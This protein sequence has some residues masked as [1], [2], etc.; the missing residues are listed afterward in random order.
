MLG[1]LIA[2]QYEVLRAIVSGYSP[3]CGT[4]HLGPAE[5]GPPLLA[6]DPQP[7]HHKYR[8]VPAGRIQYR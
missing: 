6:L 4:P 7:E 2:S 3:C 1:E 5:L 8:H